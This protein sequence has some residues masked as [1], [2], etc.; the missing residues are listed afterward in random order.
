MLTTVRPLLLRLGAL[1]CLMVAAISSPAQVFINE[2][3]FNPPG[4]QAGNQ[5]VEL[6]GPPNQ[7]LADGT[8]LVAVN[9]DSNAIPGTLQN[10][11]DLSARPLGGNGFLVLLQKTNSY[12]VNSNATV[13]VNTNGPGWGSGSSSSIGHRGNNGATDFPNASATF[14]L[15]QTTNPPT[16]HD[17]IDPDQTGA[18]H[19]SVWTNWNVLDSVGVLDNTGYGDMVY[20]KINFR[21]NALPGSGATA[22]NTVVPVAF[23]ADY[24]GRS[25][26]TT[27]WAVNDWVAGGSL[28]GALPTWSLGTFGNTYPATFSGKDLN[29]LGNPN[30]GA[31]MYN[32]V[33]AVYPGTGLVLAEGGGM[34]SYGLGLNTPPGGGVTL[35]ITADH[36]LQISSDGGNSW[37][38]SQTL[39]FNNT[40]RSLVFVRAPADNIIDTSPHWAAIRHRDRGQ[41]IDKCISRIDN[42]MPKESEINDV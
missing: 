24:V 8:Y 1:M 3:L 6:R 25:S 15:I 7:V 19:G 23:T 42:S 12:L 31:P 9:G 38:T 26:N 4:S 29:H 17:N 40:N 11:I 14:L 37:N 10:I 33:V 32:G 27:G 34:G 18:P 35:E 16:F 30:F 36:A 28:V 2:I 5:Y 22:S 39:T 13:L 21:R 20:G 41:P